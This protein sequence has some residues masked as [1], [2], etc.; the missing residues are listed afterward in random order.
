MKRR[1]LFTL[2]VIA[3]MARCLS[4]QDGFPPP[5]PDKDKPVMDG[6]NHGGEHKPG[7]RKYGSFWK[8][9][10][11]GPGKSSYLFS[12]GN[13]M[14]VIMSKLKKENPEE[15]ERL[16]NLRKTDLHAFITEIRK[17]L[18][19]PTG[20]ME[21]I[22]QIRHDCNELGD[23]IRKTQ[24]AQEKAKLEDVLRTK[25]KE[26]FEYTLQDY[27]ER[28]QRMTQ[29][30]EALKENEDYILEEHF[31]MYTTPKPEPPQP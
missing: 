1:L 2:L 21:K 8:G 16:E 31:K 19:A 3:G 22:D 23:K 15:Y 4:A 14:L 10:E 26:G 28:L 9:G 7:G 18:P 29:Q 12:R 11:H 5:P 27:T 25:I 30:L 17:H 6:P 24:D 20:T 13:A